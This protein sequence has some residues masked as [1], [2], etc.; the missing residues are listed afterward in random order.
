MARLSGRRVLVVEDEYFIAADLKRAFGEAGAEIIGPVNDLD[1]ALR[2]IVSEQIDVAVL[3]IHLEGAE[4]Y[5]V[6]DA[7]IDQAVPFLF[8]TGYDG[9]AL[10]QRY[11]AHPR[12]SKPIPAETIV[13]T[14]SKLS[15]A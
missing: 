5:P 12:L 1:A 2:M 8:L 6:V 14:L 11:R 7:L 10:P 9:W 13:D 4:S 15:E 3:D